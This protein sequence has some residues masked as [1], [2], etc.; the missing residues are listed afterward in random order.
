MFVLGTQWLILYAILLDNQ[1]S[2]TIYTLCSWEVECKTVALSDCNFGPPSPHQF[3]NETHNGESSRYIMLAN[4]CVNAL[5]IEGPYGLKSLHMGLKNAHAFEDCLD[6]LLTS[7]LPNVVGIYKIGMHPFPWGL[8]NLCKR[9]S[10]TTVTIVFFCRVKLVR[11][12]KWANSIR[13]LY[14]SSYGCGGWAFQ[15]RMITHCGCLGPILWRV[16]W[17]VKTLEGLNWTII[18]AYLLDTQNVLKNMTLH[19]AASIGRVYSSLVPRLHTLTRWNSLVNQVEFL[20]L[21]TA[22]VSVT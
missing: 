4:L 20:E 18:L 13:L 1:T 9:I 2:V 3:E 19:N 5:S 14:S 16:E 6:Y 21:A 8:L 15:E 12:W 22:F 17:L 7:M 10:I 11:S